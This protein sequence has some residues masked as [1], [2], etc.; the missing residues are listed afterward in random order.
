VAGQSCGGLQ[1]ILAAADP[2]VSTLLVLN[3]GI[4]DNNTLASAPATRDSLKAI[5]TPTLYLSGDSSDV[6]HAHAN[7]DFGFINGLPLFHGFPAGIGHSAHYRDIDGGIFAA[8]T[9]AWLNW[10][11][12]GD[13]RAANMF[14]GTRC[15]LCTN[16][17]WTVQ[18]KL[19]D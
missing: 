3:S 16:A 11:L 4:L 6:A 14:S 15:T 5:H 19:I 7:T 2:R 9:V 10:Q 1:A 17:Q 8:P 13:K 18:K 12:K